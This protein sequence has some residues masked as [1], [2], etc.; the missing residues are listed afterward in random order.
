MVLITSKYAMATSFHILIQRLLVFIHVICFFM[1]D[2]I[3]SS[4][5]KRQMFLAYPV[6]PFITDLLFLGVVSTKAMWYKSGR[7][8]ATCTK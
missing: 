4:G 6:S 8:N 3:H 1:F 7:S 5:M 2:N